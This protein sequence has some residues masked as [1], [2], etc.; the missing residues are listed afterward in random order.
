[1]ASHTLTLPNVQP[2]F[3]AAPRAAFGPLTWLRRRLDEARRYRAA[4]AELRLLSDRDLD[5]LGIS[6]YDLPA[7][8]REEAARRRRD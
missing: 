2:Y 8:A 4:M 7:I 6:P 5:D 3:D 1:M